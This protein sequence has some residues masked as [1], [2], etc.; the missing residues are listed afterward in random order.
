MS[1]HLLR[2]TILRA[3]RETPPP[4]HVA[5]TIG[6]ADEVRDLIR[7]G[8][9]LRAKDKRG[10]T[11]LHCAAAH[12][13]ADIVN[14]LL[15]G[16][17]DI[18]AR[19]PERSTPLHAAAM[20]GNPD[21]TKALV[22]RRANKAAKNNRGDTPGGMARLMVGYHKKNGDLSKSKAFEETARALGA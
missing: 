22:R 11:P 13:G 17:A 8:A 16:G 19:D 5:A 7:G 3:K 15:D 1:A 4:V 18:E 14:A 6:T 20:L 10:W 12:Q 2:A 21:S 9:D